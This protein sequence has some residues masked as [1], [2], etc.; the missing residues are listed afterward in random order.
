MNFTIFMD[1]LKDLRSTKYKYL[2]GAFV[3][4]ALVCVFG[5]LD[6]IWLIIRGPYGFLARLHSGFAGFPARVALFLLA[7][8]CAGKYKAEKKQL[9]LAAAIL[10]ALQGLLGYQFMVIAALRVVVRM[11]PLPVALVLLYLEDLRSEDES[12]RGNA[13]TAAIVAGGATLLQVL[14]GY[15]TFRMYVMGFPRF[16]VALF[17]LA[18]CVALFVESAW[19]VTAVNCGAYDHVITKEKTA[20]IAA[21][22][23]ALGAKI[24]SKKD[25]LLPAKGETAAVE[26]AIAKEIAGSEPAA[27]TGM[28]L[29][30]ADI[31]KAV[32]AAL[33]Q[34]SFFAA[35]NGNWEYKTVPGPAAVTVSK[36][37]DYSRGV[38]AYGAIIQREAVG[39]WEFSHIQ[40]VP[41]T[42]QV[43][44]LAALMGRGNTTVFFNM[45][46]F[47]RLK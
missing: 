23:A 13:M 32:A 27:D 3:I 14:S 35:N 12:V 37:E 30:E 28:E 5:V 46:V 25:E 36:G 1:Q 33:G 47:K 10:L 42:K 18:S 26:E 4:F 7:Y 44:C 16:V 9:H 2:L 29:S 34:K 6:A 15:F 21:G 38:E 20:A 11:L 19:A 22:A 24:G 8:Q 31:E 17:M 43:G 41:V 39:G 40:S 45:L